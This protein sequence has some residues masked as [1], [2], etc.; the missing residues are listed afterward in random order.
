MAR[1]IIKPIKLAHVVVKTRRYEE[2]VEWYKLVL[3]AE[4]THGDEMASFMTYD[5]E[6][7]RIAILNMPAVLPQTRA[8]AGVDHFAFT[9]ASIGDL[10]DTYERLEEAGIEPVWPINHGG[11]VSF[12][13]MDPDSN[14]VELQVDC[15]G[16]LEETLAF[17]RDGRFAIN[18]VGIDIDP[19]DLLAR[20]R[21]GESHESLTRW[22]DEVAPR[23]TPPPTAYLGQYHAA[24]LKLASA[25]GKG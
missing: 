18:P 8:M 7:H 12:Y 10:L 13:Y 19:D 6:H 5:E 20:Y 15:F 14:V 21:A 16:S 22:P 24:M 25:L 23:T 17:M 3:G 9:Y 2:L 1:E 11:T 4:V